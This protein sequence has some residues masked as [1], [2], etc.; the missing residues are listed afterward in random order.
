MASIGELLGS[1]REE[2]IRRKAQEE[3]ERVLSDEQ[4]AQLKEMNEIHLSIRSKI[5]TLEG[6]KRRW[7][8]LKEE[9]EPLLTKKEREFIG[10]YWKGGYRRPKYM[11]MR[12][13]DALLRRKFFTTIPK[14]WKTM[15]MNGIP[16][17]KFLV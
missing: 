14:N 11:K 9:L 1:K 3:S 6:V 4:I 16:K 15:E 13:V 7:Y 5:D 17:I 12:T 2:E 10:P 8:L